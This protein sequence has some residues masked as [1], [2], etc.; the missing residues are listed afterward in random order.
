MYMTSVVTSE[1]ISLIGACPA[2]QLPDFEE[3]GACPDF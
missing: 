3:H 1:S 2:K